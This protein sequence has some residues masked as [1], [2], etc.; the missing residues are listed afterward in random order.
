MRGLASE[1]LSGGLWAAHPSNLNLGFV[2]RF[3]LLVM[4]YHEVATAMRERPVKG[5]HDPSLRR[6]PRRTSR[7]SQCL[8]PSPSLC[9]EG[10]LLEA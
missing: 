7:L 6:L 5:L 8:R 9:G 4:P 2:L 3:P 10:L 1:S